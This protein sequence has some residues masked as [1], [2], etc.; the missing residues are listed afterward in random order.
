MLKTGDSLLYTP[1]V[2]MEQQTL[3]LSLW[4]HLN[5]QWVSIE[6]PVENRTFSNYIQTD[7]LPQGSFISKIPFK[8]ASWLLLQP[9]FY[10]PAFQV[11]SRLGQ[12]CCWY[13]SLSH[14]QKTRD[15]Y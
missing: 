3:S 13:K 7:L 1:E 2:F 14:F 8:C 15:C 9:P 4:T 12:L 11:V 5:G 6:D 10:L